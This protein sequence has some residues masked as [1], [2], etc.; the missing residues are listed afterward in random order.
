[1]IAAIKFMYMWIRFRFLYR[2]MI[3]DC[4]QHVRITEL[5]SEI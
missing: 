4:D 5:L 2:I 3:Y 1:M